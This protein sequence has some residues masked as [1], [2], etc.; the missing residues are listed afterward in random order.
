MT[1]KT[2]ARIS[3]VSVGCLVVAC[4]ALLI[5]SKVKVRAGYYEDDLALAVTA[6]ERFLHLYHAQA[7]ETIY[8]EAAPVFKANVDRSQ[9]LAAMHESYKLHGAIRGDT[10]VVA[11][12]FPN[13]VRFTRVLQTE[14]AGEVTEMSA[15]QTDGT[16]AWLLLMHRAGGRDPIKASVPD[17]LRCVAS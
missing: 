13:Q 3:A 14:K 12:C 10:D 4:T 9:A 16:K 5:A 11:T 17:N 2:V 6:R 15:W 8:D 7:F 1:R